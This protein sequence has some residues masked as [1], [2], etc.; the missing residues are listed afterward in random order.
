MP[1]KSN[2]KKPEPYLWDILPVFLPDPAIEEELDRWNVLEFLRIEALLRSPQVMELH[3]EN[4]DFFEEVLNLQD[5]SEKFPIKIPLSVSLKD[6]L[7]MEYRVMGGWQVLAGFHHRL[8]ASPSMKVEFK[9]Q[10][11]ADKQVELQSE[12]E[13]FNSSSGLLNLVPL[14]KKE[15]GFSG[16]FQVEERRI[17]EETLLA[18]D[19]RYLWVRI[20]AA[21]PP[22]RILRELKKELVERHKTIN[23]PSPEI[24]NVLFISNSSELWG[25]FQPTHPRKLPPRL[26]IKT[27]ID[28]FK[29]YD[30]HQNEG[31]S[32][33][34]IAIQVYDDSTKEDLVKKAY[35]RVHKLIGYA[36]KNN[37]PPPA[38]FLNS[39]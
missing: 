39:K 33:G 15:K 3:K 22:T 9:G 13:I 23:I 18:K 16:V 26:N 5:T 31:K 6:K 24:G 30:L 8:L 7:F 29:C 25:V 35:K 2:R 27:W 32:Y 38:K 10:W 17:L 20:D 21:H 14:Y 37:W 19:P 11:S 12:I 28:Y 1:A 36:E 34:R 4:L